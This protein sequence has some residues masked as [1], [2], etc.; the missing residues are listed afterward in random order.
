M[1]RDKSLFWEL[2]RF[3]VIGVYGTL[4]D[5]AMEG[6]LTSFVSSRAESSAPIAAFFLMFLI[7][8][9]GFLFSTPASWS[10]T[11]VW[12]FRNVAKESEKKAKSAKGLLVFTF[13]AALALLLGALIQFLGY[14]TCLEWSGWGINILWGFNFDQMFTQGHLE[15]FWAWATVMVIRTAFTMVFNYV[16]RKLFIY[17]APKEEEKQA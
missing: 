7:S 1:N 10:L 3:V 6:W 2:V 12:G 15:V 13:W 4:I 17:K 11:S 14:M 5:L 16:T 9:L 8:V